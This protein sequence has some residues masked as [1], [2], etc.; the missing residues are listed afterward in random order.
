M[1]I[2]ARLAP[3][4]LACALVAPGFGGAAHAAVSPAEAEALQGQLR[5]WIAGL[6]GPDADLGDRMVRV[7]PDGDRYRVELP[8]A[9][10]VGSDGATV[11]GSPVVGLARKLDG[12][13]WDIPSLRL[14]SPLRVETPDG[15][16]GTW[17][18]TLKLGEQD[19][20]GVLDPTLAT[21]STFDATLRD[22]ISELT[23]ADRTQ[24]THLD[25]SVGHGMVEPVVNGRVTLR[26]EASGENLTV[27]T[28]ERAGPSGRVTVSAASLRSIAVVERVDFDRLRTAIRA[29]SGLAP[30][31]LAAANDDG[32]GDL[33]PE[34]RARLRTLVMALR[35]LLSGVQQ[36]TTLERVRIDAGGQAGTLA[37][38]TIGGSGAAADGKLDSTMRLVLEGIDTPLVPPGPL[39]DYL[40]RRISLK[41]HVSNIPLDALM[42]LLLR[43]I[44][45][46]E[47]EILRAQAEKLLETSPVRAAIDELV[48]DLGP[49]TVKGTGAMT[50][51]GPDEVAGTANISA[52]GLDALIRRANTV[53]ELRMAAPALIFLK[54]IGE[55]R[56]E[57]ITWRVEYAGGRTTVNGTDLA[58]LTAPAPSPPPASS[59][60]RQRGR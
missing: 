12:D 11:T 41:P 31:A 49:A 13:R 45:G 57:A 30:T 36:E 58:A 10:P 43:G 17:R 40:P 6:L 28:A 52:T 51:A 27:T 48:L 24:S 21:V 42:Q 25:R 7:A 38:L 15:A 60:G 2:A 8:L 53:P 29:L 47:A 54:G 5:A 59:P 33:T 20:R 39:R 3:T 1:S 37:K 32:Q 4:L 16:G 46:E 55:Q 34:E 50:V 56:G 23:T 44:D 26:G 35:D 18:L 22:G 19:A 9:G 14:P